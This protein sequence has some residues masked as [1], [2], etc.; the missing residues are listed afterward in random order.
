MI[1]DCVSFQFPGVV[2]NLSEVNTT[3]DHQLHGDSQMAA[4]NPR[5]S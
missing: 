5:V 1:K 3:S 4:G 2:L